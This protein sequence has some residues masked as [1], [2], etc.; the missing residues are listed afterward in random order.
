M[1]IFILIPR[2]LQY[3]LFSYNEWFEKMIHHFIKN[4]LADKPRQKMII[5]IDKQLNYTGNK[6]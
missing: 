1:Y 4:I 3:S 2:A 6:L 5:A